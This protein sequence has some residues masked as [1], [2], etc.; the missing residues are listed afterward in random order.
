VEGHHRP[1][2]ASRDP[3]T[4]AGHQTRQIG[5]TSSQFFSRSTRDFRAI[6]ARVRLPPSPARIIKSPRL[7]AL[8]VIWMD[9]AASACHRTHQTGTSSSHFSSRSTRDFRAIPAS[10]R[11][12]PSP[13]QITKPPRLPASLV[14]WMDP[15]ASACHRTHQIGT[16]SS[17]FSSRS[18]RA[19]G[20]LQISAQRLP[21]GHPMV[22]RSRL[23]A[24][25][26]T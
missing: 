10:V 7:L 12:P 1:L 23:P 17:H 11:R 3:A 14:I 26:V 9:P 25:L 6:P 19:F 8:L 4:S 20:A 16:A 13:A 5:T 24:A 22:K 15:A 21:N 18:T 2:Q